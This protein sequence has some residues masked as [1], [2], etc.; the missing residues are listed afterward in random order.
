MVIIITGASNGIG[1]RTALQLASDTNNTVIAI[2]R[3][4]EGL[5]RLNDE[6]IKVN[7]ACRIETIS[8]DLKNY[9]SISSLLIPLVKKI[10]SR[11]DVLINNAGML[12]KK[13]I[14]SL[15]IKDFEE[16]YAA[17]VFAPVMLIKELLPM[18][19]GQH[20]SHIV[21]ISSMGGVQGSVK[22]P[23]LSAYSSSKA[24]IIN[25]TESLAVELKEKNI[26]VN[27][28][29]FGSVETEMFSEAFPK[30]KAGMAAHEAASY[31]ADFGLNGHK[32]FN[33]KTLQVS[34]STP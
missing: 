14:E 20:P 4:A 32:Y 24:A 34:S 22:F 10:V 7:P 27:C 19:G 2:S 8:F 12:V 11:V 13:N 16:S 30:V 33:G 3:S 28:I 25:L 29:A 1:Y 23:E 5:S 6:S 15:S 17:N 26:S 21:N 31:L 9:A 18:M